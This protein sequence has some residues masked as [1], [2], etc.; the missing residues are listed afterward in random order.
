MEAKEEHGD[1]GQQVTEHVVVPTEHV[2]SAEKESDCDDMPALV[3]SDDDVMPALE[4]V[5]GPLTCEE[6]LKEAANGLVRALRNL[7]YMDKHG[8]PK[9][10]DE[11]FLEIEHMCTEKNHLDV[12]NFGSPWEMYRLAVEAFG[13]VAF[14]SGKHWHIRTYKKAYAHVM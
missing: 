9:W 8:Y 5:S 6:A 12:P 7:M 1:A 2:L 13:D 11:I 3:D 10:M 14:K 4:W